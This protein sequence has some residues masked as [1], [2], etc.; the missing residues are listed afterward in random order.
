MSMIV[1]YVVMSMS[2]YAGTRYEQIKQEMQPVKVER[3]VGISE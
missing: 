1:F 2:F 3:T